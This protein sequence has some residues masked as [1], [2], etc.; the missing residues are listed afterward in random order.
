MKLLVV[1]LQTN[2]KTATS[3]CHLIF[4]YLS[5]NRFYGTKNRLL[6]SRTI[7]LG[8]ADVCLPVCMSILSLTGLTI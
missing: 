1:L 6:F 2:T 8:W 5:M 7:M 4:H 3:V